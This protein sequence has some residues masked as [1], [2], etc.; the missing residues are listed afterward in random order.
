VSARPIAII[1][2]DGRIA[3]V[4]RTND[5]LWAVC[6]AVVPT[7]CPPIPG[8]GN[9][10]VGILAAEQHL[11]WH[12]RGMPVCPDCRAPLMKAGQKRCRTGTCEVP[13]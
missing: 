2:T 6:C 9:R 7:P 12:S 13:R 8:F 1:D 4:A 11:F 3:A 5:T 10:T